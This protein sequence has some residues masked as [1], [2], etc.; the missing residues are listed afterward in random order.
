MD[1]WFE[2]ITANCRLEA[3]AA[4]ALDE[5]GFAVID[6]PVPMTHLE[7]L[8]HAYDRAMREA[9]APDLAI[10]RTTTRVHDFVNRGSEFDCLYVHPPLLA[11]CCRTIGQPFKLSNMLGRTLRPGLHPQD[12]HVDFARDRHGWPMIGFIVMI[13]DF[14]KENGATCFLPGSH[15]SSCEANESLREMDLVPACGPSGSVIVYNGSVLHGHGPNET[16]E[17]RRSIQGAYI[18]RDA[19]GFDLASRM[20]V[21][22]KERIGSLARYLIA[23]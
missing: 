8:R 13:D 5:D 20:C 19:T 23:V 14:R 21:E 7:S 18:R 12:L 10:G 9:T 11:A 2:W 4:R 6:G 22:T 1:D 16:N 15:L 17:P 3:S